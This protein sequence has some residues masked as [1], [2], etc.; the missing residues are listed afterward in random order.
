MSAERCR[1]KPTELPMTG[2]AS[3]GQTPSSIGTVTQKTSAV[4]WSR[5]TEELEPPRT[6]A[7]PQ[8]PTCH[9]QVC[10]SADKAYNIENKVK[11]H[12]HHYRCTPTA[13]G[14]HFRIPCCHFPTAICSAQ[15]ALL[16]WST[17]TRLR[18]IEFIDAYLKLASL[19][20][21][22]LEARATASLPIRFRFRIRFDCRRP[23]HSAEG[24]AATWKCKNAIN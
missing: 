19:L 5:N 14:E 1:H 4:A 12:A 8:L 9:R 18:L 21:C 6:L 17:L 7:N 23:G 24:R 20:P 11:Y 13:R 22:L 2:S 16:A 10:R 3:S 15:V